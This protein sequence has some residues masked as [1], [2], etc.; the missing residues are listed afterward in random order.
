MNWAYDSEEKLYHCEIDGWYFNIYELEDGT[1]N[2]I[3]DYNDEE[4]QDLDGIFSTVEEAQQEAQAIYDDDISEYIGDD[5]AGFEYE[6]GA[7]TT[8]GGDKMKK[9]VAYDWDEDKYDFGCDDFSED[10][11]TDYNVTGLFMVIREKDKNG[12]YQTDVWCED[13]VDDSYEEGGWMLDE[14]KEDVEDFVKKNSDRLFKGNKDQQEL[15]IVAWNTHNITPGKHYPASLYEPESW[16]DPII[17]SGKA[18][19]EVV[20][21][22]VESM[23]DE[24]VNEKYREIVNSLEN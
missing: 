24:E 12:Q 14:L 18:A 10:Y 15:W 23:S 22:D 11:S 21:R 6:I 20:L 17:R 5:F 13:S 4:L 2:L 3:V 16:D 19:M 7:K 1:F 8:V 9:I